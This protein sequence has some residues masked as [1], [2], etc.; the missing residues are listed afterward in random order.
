MRLAEALEQSATA[1]L[2]R[3]ANAHGVTH[4]DTTT[5]DEF[6]ARIAERF[7]EPAY[8]EDQLRALSADEQAV[9]ESARASS[10]ELRGLLVD[11][12]YPGAAENL[13]DRGWLYRVF[14]VAGPLRGEVFVVPDEILA[15]VPYSERPAATLEQTEPPVEVRWTDPSFSLFALASALTRQGDHLEQDVRAWSQEPGGWDWEARW[16]FLRQLASSAGLLAH[17]PDGPLAAAPTLPRVLD[18]PPALADR[19][20]R[21]YLQ[22][23]GWSELAHAAVAA[24][25]HGEDSDLVDAIGLRHA[26]VDV[27]DHLPEG[28]W[29]RLSDVSAWLQRTRPTL[30]REQLNP[31]GLVRVQSVDWAGLEEPLLEYFVLGPLY[32]LGRITASR[33]GQSFSIREPSRLSAETCR[34]EGAELIAPARVQLG[35]LLRA[36]RYLVLHERGRV[37]RYHLVQAHVASALGSGGSIAECRQLLTRLTQAPLPPVV[38]ERLAAWDQR[39]GALN[40]RP[41]VVLEGRTA[42]E[43]EAAV[44]D[45]RVRPFVRA[46]FGPTVA[47]I[48]AA[49]ALELASSLRASDHLPRV[50]AA[51]RLAA[52]ARHAYAGLVDQQVLEFLLVS[53]LAFRSA[54]PERLTELEGSSALLQRLEHQFPPERLAELR[55]SADRLAGVLVSAPKPARRRRARHPK[56]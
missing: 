46:R 56:L 43:L 49:D 2:R 25:A 29:L 1:T 9:L 31:R 5:R 6:I 8:I 42:A 21:S 50:D 47:E 40:I 24:P 16:T 20:W 10:G 32:W 4:D 14:A 41:A 52:D 7:S 23:R 30:I 12:E 22:D 11:S 18:D 17:R 53:L 28:S 27:L 19:L 36:E 38:E 37:S 33:D 35:A 51:L 34:W 44:A 15:H 3:V 54:W 45:E 48:A 55:R 39:F 13:A 26:I